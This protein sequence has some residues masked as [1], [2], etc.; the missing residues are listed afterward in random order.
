MKIK[1]IIIICFI[2]VTVSFA[3]SPKYDL[4]TFSK[5]K[6]IKTDSCETNIPVVAL[7]NYNRI[8]KLLTSGVQWGS[9]AIVIGAAL[10]SAFNPNSYFKYAMTALG[11]IIA[12]AGGL[13][14]GAFSN[15]PENYNVGKNNFGLQVNYAATMS[16]ELQRYV[17][18]FGLVFRKP[19]N[20][21]FT[22]DNY[23]VYFGDDVTQSSTQ[24]NK[25]SKV[26]ST[27]YG[28]EITKVGYNRIANFVYGIDVGYSSGT[29][30]DFEVLDYTSFAGWKP[31]S[32]LYFDIVLGG[33]LN[34]TKNIHVSLKY[35]AELFGVFRWQELS[36]TFANSVNHMV[37]FSVYTFLL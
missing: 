2:L 9:V 36:S 23:F 33:N 10:E 14:Y 12:S 32:T 37:S 1:Q 24:S 16:E 15:I 35:K 18:S 7:I 4:I 13:V 21:Y 31:I 26:H 17:G 25:Y 27:N 34:V 29:Y 3:Q 8:D 6:I 30:S 20:C 11:G 19:N 5:S 22:P 28:I